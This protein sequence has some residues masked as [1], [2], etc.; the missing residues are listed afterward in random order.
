MHTPRACTTTLYSKRIQC[1]LARQYC[2]QGRH[3]CTFLAHDTTRGGV[4]VCL[5]QTSVESSLPKLRRERKQEQI[6]CQLLAVRTHTASS[7][8]KEIHNSSQ[9]RAVRA[10]T[11][12]RLCKQVHSSRQPSAKCVLTAS[13]VR[14]QVRNSCQPLTVR[15][16]TA[17][18]VQKRVHNNVSSV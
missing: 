4:A 11:A 1:K 17:T 5:R 6:N 18:R 12:S 3:L 14:K 10:R 13:R 8:R 9:P 7:V 16:H 15:A 2:T